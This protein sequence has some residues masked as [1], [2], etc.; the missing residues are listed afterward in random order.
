MRFFFALPFRVLA[1]GEGEYIGK[2]K[3][4]KTSI[5]AIL[6]IVVLNKY[7]G[8]NCVF[9]L[10]LWN[11]LPW[12]KMIF[13]RFI[14][15]FH[16]PATHH[17]PVNKLCTNSTSQ[18]I[19]WYK[20]NVWGNGIGGKTTPNLISICIR[21]NETYNHHL[22]SWTHPLIV[23]IWNWFRLFCIQNIFFQRP[24]IWTSLLPEIFHLYFAT[25]IG[26]PL[27]V[28]NNSSLNVMYHTFFWKICC[29]NQ[30]L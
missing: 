27:F 10:R 18:V 8:T 6:Y 14:A 21:P 28:R 23:D 4:K 3:V 13:L 17:I 22:F 19:L 12:M 5:L 25:F 26:R 30:F 15:R 16:R 11:F 9:W 2:T 20:V 7:Q 24:S 1:V 29:T